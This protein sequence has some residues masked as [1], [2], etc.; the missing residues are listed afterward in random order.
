MT[1]VLIVGGGVAGQVA[2]MALQRVGI[3]AVVYEADAAQV[4]AEFVHDPV[5]AA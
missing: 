2:A 3:R 4:T 1:R 5:A